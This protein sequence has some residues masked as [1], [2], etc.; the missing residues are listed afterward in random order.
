MPGEV[1]A[2]LSERFSASFGRADDVPSPD[3]AC[4][5]VNMIRKQNND[6]RDYY[7]DSTITIPS[8][9]W[10]TKPEIPDAEEISQIPY[11]ADQPENQMVSL[12]DE[13]QPNK[14]EGAYENKEQYLKTQ[15]DLL[16]ED[17]LRPL[18]KSVSAVRASPYLDEAEYPQDASIGLYEPVSLIVFV[19]FYVS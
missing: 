3:P 2:R 7:D 16:R 14:A 18:R 4:R 15:Y 13:L 11:N 9:S 8:G 5:L 1:N 19:L 17:S 12:R 10:M 6:I